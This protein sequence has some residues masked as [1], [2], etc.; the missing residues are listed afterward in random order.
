MENPHLQILV[1]LAKIDGE[2]DESELEIIREIG[3]SNS[4]S[5]EDIEKAI[6]SAE[7]SDPI[8]GVEDFTD[9]EKFELMYNLVLVMKADGILHKE[10]MKFC[11]NLTRKM[12]FEEDAL[13]E[14]VSNAKVEPIEHIN[15]EEIISKA[16]KYY[17]SK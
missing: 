1:Q 9:E 12:G 10:E 3:S 14:L 6:K 5:D 15:K 8:S 16:K 4:I 7:A 17:Q 13:F 11:M 2:A